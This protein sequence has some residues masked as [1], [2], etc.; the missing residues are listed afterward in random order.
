MGIAELFEVG[1]F[2]ALW[3]WSNP[4]LTA[5]IYFCIAAGVILQIVFQKKC[6]SPFARWL[7]IVLCIVGMIISECLWQVITG[8]DRIAV[9]LL[10]GSMI[11]IFLGALLVILI[12][13][14]KNRKQR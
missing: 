11:C 8:W 7:L 9:D 3:N 1:F 6:R 2:T 13:G 4:I 5:L 14:L 12:S 10:Y